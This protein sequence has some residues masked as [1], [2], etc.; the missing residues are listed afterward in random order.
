[1]R[2]LR[3]F[4]WA[5]VLAAAFVYITSTGHWNAGR[6]LGP[7]RSAGAAW[8]EPA[9]AAPAY[10]VDEQNNID[11]Y[12]KAREATVNITSVVYQ[13]DFFFQVYP[14]EG[15]GSGFIINPEGEI[16]TNNHVVRGSRQVTVTLHDKKVYKAKVLDLDT[17]NDLALLKIEAGHKLPT[18]PL[19]NS[20]SL[21]VGQKVL[22]IGNP[23]GF[24]GTLTTG[25]VSSLDRSIQTEET[26]KMEGMIQTDAAI[27]PGNSGGP[28]LDSRGTVIGINTAIY[29]PQGNIGIGFAMPINRAKSMLEEIQHKGHVS[30]PAPLGIR[31]RYVSGDLAEMLE[32]PAEGGLLIENVER[33]SAAEAAGLHGARQTVVVGGLYQIGV[34][35]DLIVAVDGQKVEGN[36]TL[37]RVMGGK[38]GGDSLELTIYRGGRTQKVQVHLG[39][40]PQVL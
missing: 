33:G 12:K 15:A 31:T 17:R 8:T 38:R 3:P 7:A 35:G 30:R 29:G 39:E 23:F 5:V 18:L 40:A 24:G 14:V 25:I 10:T 20:D 34:G 22:A 27:N 6:L 21:V 16:L 26:R 28:L 32:L 9:S 19:G 4:L 2:T 13:Q 36:E 37:P 1:M 11:V